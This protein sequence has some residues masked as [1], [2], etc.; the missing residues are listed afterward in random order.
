M[1]EHQRRLWKNMIDLI[2]S[3]LHNETKDF[4]EIVG[5]LEGA[6]DASEIKDTVLINQWYDFWTPLEARRAVEGNQVNRTKAMKELAAMKEFLAKH[7]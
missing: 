3:Y 6:L 1:N 5:K 7:L 2:E 4:Y